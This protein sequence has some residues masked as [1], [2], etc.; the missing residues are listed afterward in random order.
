M[1]IRPQ[2]GFTLIELVITVGIIG[3]IAAVALP[4]YNEYVL[5]SKR[6]EGTSWLLTT[7]QLLERCSNLNGAYNHP[8]C[9]AGPILTENELYNITIVSAANT[10]ILTATPTFVDIECGNLG[11]N[12]TDTKTVSVIVTPIENCW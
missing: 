7:A 8:N 12:Q 3:I 4:S 11:L 2:T 5:N 1:N 10:F 6:T 9:E